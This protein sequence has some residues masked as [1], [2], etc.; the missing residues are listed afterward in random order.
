MRWSQFA[1]FHNSSSKHI[2]TGEPSLWS[3]DSW[4]VPPTRLQRPLTQTSSSQGAKN[5]VKDV[6]CVRELSDFLQTLKNKS[7]RG[8]NYISRSYSNM[9]GEA[10]KEVPPNT[11]IPP[12]WPSSIS[13]SLVKI[14]P[15]DIYKFSLPE[16]SRFLQF[17]I[18]RLK[19]KGQSE[20]FKSWP[21]A[22]GIPSRRLP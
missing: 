2:K 4:S 14:L 11:H 5:H 9:K 12:L 3:T 1:S 22:K 10:G 16:P 21:G 19:G 18:S 7:V 13:I 20:T 8:G 15:S 6:K 17:Q